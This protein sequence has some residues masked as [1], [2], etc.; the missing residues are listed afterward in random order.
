[1]ICLE[2]RLFSVYI[3]GAYLECIYETVLRCGHTFRPS[4]RVGLN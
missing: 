3:R 2:H 1:M 4:L